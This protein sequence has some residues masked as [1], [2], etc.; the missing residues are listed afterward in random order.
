MK[1]A[2]ALFLAVLMLLAAGCGNPEGASEAAQG[3]SA[4]ET[5]PAGEVSA[6][7]EAEEEILRDSLPEKDFGGA[8]LLFT[9]DDLGKAKAEADEKPRARQNVVFEA[10]YFMGKLGRNRTV[11]LAE[12]GV[13]LP[14]DLSGVVYTD[15]ADWKVELL[16]GLREMGYEIDLNRL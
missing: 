5:E 10:G 7:P 2:L 15:A 8:V 3:E 14:S 12:H 9:A 16:K 1:K 13:E 11:L 6:E 4:F